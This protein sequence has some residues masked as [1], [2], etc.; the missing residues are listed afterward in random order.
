[1]KTKILTLLAIATIGISS[2]S[3][4]D[5]Q[6]K[7]ATTNKENNMTTK[8]PYVKKYTNADYY[9]D[10]KLQADVVL[11]AYEEMLAHYGIELSKFM[12]DNLWITD[13][14]LGDFENMGMAGFFWVNDP[15]AKYF[16]H[17]IYLLPGQMIAEHY[18]VSTEGFDAKMESWVVKKG[19]CYNFSIGEVTPNAPAVP[20]CQEVN[21]VARS[22]IVQNINEII[23]LKKI[24]TPHFL[25]AG[26]GGAVVLELASFH[27][28][29]GLRFSNPDVV[30]TDVLTAK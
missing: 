7:C 14:E 10:G 26:D 20:E 16:G 25:M 11:R 19:M 9:K 3:C 5:S 4:C 30:F 23:H 8:T 12:R 18:H 13:F 29:A 27:D 21:R 1:M 15:E 6:Q 22:F 2:T 28:G 17:E 24:E